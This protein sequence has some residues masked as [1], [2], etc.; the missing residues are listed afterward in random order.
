MA[1]TAEQFEAS[2]AR[3]RA[4]TADP[5]AGLFGP[6]SKTW[7]ISRE[8]VLFLGGGR[9]SLLQLAHPFVA[10]AV[11][12]HSATLTDPAGRFARTF[13][14]VFAMVYGDVDA[15]LA[16]A[17][18]VYRVHRT[19][20]GTFPTRVGPYP[21]G[22]GYE[23]N[24]AESQLWVAAT[25]WDTTIQVFELCVR[26]L[27]TSEKAAYYAEGRRF[28]ALFAIPEEIIPPTWDDFQAYCRRMWSS[29]ALAV[30][31]AAAQIGAFLMRSPS[32]VVTP[33]WRWYVTMTAGLLPEPVREQFGMRFG[34][35][36]RAVFA[37]SVRGLRGALPSL[38]EPVRT[39]PPYREA[40]ARL[41]VAATTGTPLDRAVD[42]LLHRAAQ[43]RSR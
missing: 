38:P 24:H 16:A 25:L 40:L 30:G 34:A 7:E 27:A 6:A 42:R 3:L 32:L 2:L 21:A 35:R 23:A 33:F 13:E 14:Q 22:S 28:A 9:A 15:A 39:L 8:A 4:T 26:P 11:A 29:P 31:P 1:L 5:R 10:Q 43:G 12:E 20:V 37:A 17:R 19:V 18:R 41:G 36:E